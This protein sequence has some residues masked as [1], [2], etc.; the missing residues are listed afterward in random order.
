MIPNLTAIFKK[1]KGLWVTM[2]ESHKKVV[3][4]DKNIMKAYNGAIKKGHKVPLIF[5]V[6]KKN[7]PFVGAWM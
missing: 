1:Y 6:P 4:A 7:L 2:D 3:S 5:K